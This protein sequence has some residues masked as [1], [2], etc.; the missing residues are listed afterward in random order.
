M[1]EC[2]GYKEFD[3]EL[4]SIVVGYGTKEIKGEERGCRIYLRDVI[5][6]KYCPFCRKKME[7][8]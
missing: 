4:G 7:N 2:E 6:F 3:K 8:K 1:C 5:V